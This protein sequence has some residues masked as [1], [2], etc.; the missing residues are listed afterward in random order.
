MGFVGCEAVAPVL[1]RGWVSSEKVK[2]LCWASEGQLGAGMV[3][4]PGPLPLASSPAPD[5]HSAGSP[6]P[7]AVIP[8]PGM[9]FVGLLTPV[10]WVV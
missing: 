5:C 1:S 6:T 10:V 3:E 2:P 7:Q 4:L 9:P 8:P